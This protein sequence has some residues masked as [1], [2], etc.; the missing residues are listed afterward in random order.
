MQFEDKRAY[1]ILHFQVSL[2]HL[3]KSGKEV[4]HDRNLE[5]GSHAEA[6]K[7]VL[8]A[9]LHHMGFLAGFLITLDHLSRGGTTFFRMGPLLQSYSRKYSADLSTVQ[10][11]GGIFLIMASSENYSL[12]QN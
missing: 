2:H 9:G 4:K 8:L 3:E 7:E 6:T 5:A 12:S 10:S 1:F 11:Y